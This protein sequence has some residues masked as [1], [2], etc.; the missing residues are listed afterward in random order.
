MALIELHGAS[1]AYVSSTLAVADVSLAIDSGEFVAIVGRNGCGKSTLCRLMH[2]LL[3]PT[4]GRALVA[5]IDT[6]DPTQRTT[7]RST[8]AMVFQNPDNQIVATVVDQDVAFGPENLGV[9]QSELR[10]RVRDALEAVGMWEH[11]DRAPHLLSEG[12][13]QRVAIAGALALHPRCLI[14]DEATSL[15][16]PEAKRRVAEI[17]ARAN[18]DGVA[19]VMVTHDM[20]EARQ[21][22]RLVALDHGSVA[23]DGTP[24]GVL[25]RPDLMER[26]GLFAPP[27]AR[28]ATALRARRPSFPA[29]L[30]TVDAVV[31]SVAAAVKGS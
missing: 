27:A 11:R 15:L 16:D 26:L 4:A 17:A 13:K 19:V 7:V 12:E 25:S 22:R 9:P 28:L 30:L 6:K 5:G 18:S 29:Q 23:Y 14:L 31:D 24:A 20:A 3:L 1:F 2:G 21:A 8:V 10:R